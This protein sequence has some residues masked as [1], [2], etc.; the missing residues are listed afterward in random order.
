MY[1]SFLPLCPKVKGSWIFQIEQHLYWKDKAATRKKKRI[2]SLERHLHWK[3]KASSLPFSNWT[4]FSRGTTST[5]RKEQRRR[6]RHQRKKNKEEEDGKNNKK[7]SILASTHLLSTLQ[8][9]IYKNYTFYSDFGK[10]DFWLLSQ[11][12]CQISSIPLP[13]WL[14]FIVNFKMFRLF[15]AACCLLDH[16]RFKIEFMTRVFNVFF[17]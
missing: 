9:K 13:Y 11:D 3:D 8:S 15:F 4:A 16:W 1:F 6:R 2:F 17:L 12:T 10:M 7:N 5:G 14:L